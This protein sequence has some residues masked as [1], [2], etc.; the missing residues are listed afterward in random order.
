AI[1]VFRGMLE[2]DPTA[3]NI[4]IYLGISYEEK[5][6]LENAYSE[7]AKISKNSSQYYDAVSHIALILKEQ[8][9]T[10]AAI[11]TLKDAIDANRGNLELYLNLSSLYESIDRP[12]A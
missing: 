5:G 8:G 1:S 3:D 2:K 7:F 4:R 9:K 12:Q 10:D 11:T 6:D